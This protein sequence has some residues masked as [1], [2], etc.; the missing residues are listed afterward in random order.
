MI[1]IKSDFLGIKLSNPLILASGIMGVSV[2]SMKKIAD[3]GA[4]AVT[5]KSI[6]KEERLGHNNPTM[7]SFGDVFMNAVG[8]SNPGM[9]EAKKEFSDIGRIGV[10]VIGSVIG[11][12]A[13]DFVAVIEEL[14][15]IK[16]DAIEIPLSCPHTPGFG[17]LAGHGTPEATYRITKAVRKATR[18]PIII[19]LSANAPDLIGVAK[20]AENAGADAINMGNTHGPGMRIDIDS[21]KPIMDFKV[22]GISGPAITPVTVRCVYDIYESTKI[23]ILGT[24]GITTGRDA[25]EMMMAGASALGVGTGIYYRGF[26]VFKKIADEM[27]DWMK[28]KGYLSL[29][30][31]IGVAHEG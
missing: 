29:N 21:G 25:I 26:D 11:T 23:P 30:E 7:F 1:T 19:K 9:V 28:K 15:D 8:Y 22:G 24:G 2:G 16:F 13:D 6:S 20:A 18:L 4:G 5:I 12:E 3:N 10:P 31:I 17:V 14:K 27:K